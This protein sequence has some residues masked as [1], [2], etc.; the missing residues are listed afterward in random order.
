MPDEIK[1]RII[2]V[3][4]RQLGKRMK[5]FSPGNDDPLF[6]Y[7]VG[8]DSVSTLE[9]LVALENEFNMDID[10]SEINADILYSV[11]TIAEYIGSRI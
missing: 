7:G 10:E 4:S 9:L 6:E 1:Q 3:I 2:K 8:V 11:S 5:Q